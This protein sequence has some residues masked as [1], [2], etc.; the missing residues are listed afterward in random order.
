MCA[1]LQCMMWLVVKEA[2]L[3]G[4]VKVFVFSAHNHGIGGC[5]RGEEWLKV[6]SRPSL[7]PDTPPT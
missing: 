7:K 1:A 4:L 6:S 2:P 5:R 3:E